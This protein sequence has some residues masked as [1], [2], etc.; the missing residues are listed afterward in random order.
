MEN[1]A[2]LSDEELV[3]EYRLALQ[4]QAEVNERI[5]TLEDEHFSRTCGRT[6]LRWLV[7]EGEEYEFTENNHN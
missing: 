1:L 2:L 5:L 7:E 6:A 3:D 4:Q